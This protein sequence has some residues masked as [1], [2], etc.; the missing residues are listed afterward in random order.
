MGFHRCL[1]A[2]LLPAC[3]TTSSLGTERE[4]APHARVV[5]SPLPGDETIRLVPQAIEPLLPSADRIA[6][7]VEARL[8]PQ[9][10]VDV[11]YCVSPA[12]K[13]VEATLERSSMLDQFDHAVM[14]DIV[15]WQFDVQPGPDSVRTCDRATIVYRPHRI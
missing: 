1:Y 2:L 14:A 12:G 9:A 7:V 8:G 3:A 15:D 11:R 5:L 6:R 13:I 10:S 4:P